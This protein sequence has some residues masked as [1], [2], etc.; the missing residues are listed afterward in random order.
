MNKLAHC[1]IFKVALFLKGQN[2]GRDQME[3][4]CWG[5]KNLN[6]WRRRLFYSGMRES[7]KAT[8]WATCRFYR[9]ARP[10]IFIRK[11]VPHHKNEVNHSTYQTFYWN[12]STAIVHFALL[13]RSEHPKSQPLC[14]PYC[15]KT[16]LLIPPCTGWKS[17]GRR[18]G[19]E[20]RL[21]EEG[22]GREGIQIVKLVKGRCWHCVPPQALF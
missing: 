21:E 9:T 22:V 6:R 10:L 11:K 1:L 5:C 13:S 18:K 19:E 12:P 2:D 15:Q 17:W 4:W 7:L 8:M 14:R 3:T 16:K 20:M